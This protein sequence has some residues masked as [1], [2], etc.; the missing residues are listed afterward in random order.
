M[1]SGERQNAVSRRIRRLIEKF[2]YPKYR[3]SYVA[4]QNR[5]FLARQ[6][7]EIRGAMPQS[8][9]GKLI[10]KPQNV[11]SERLENPAYGKLTLT[12]LFEV[13]QKLDR[14]VIVR[15]VD[16]PTFITLTNDQSEDAACPNA[17][18]EESLQNYLQSAEAS[19]RLLKTNPAPKNRNLE[20]LETFS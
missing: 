13:A 10:G 18:S 7:R 3:H 9:F 15:L 1:E 14:A 19:T 12:T 17:Y 8:E 11:V 16:F 5:Q 20:L 6:F 2:R 4:A